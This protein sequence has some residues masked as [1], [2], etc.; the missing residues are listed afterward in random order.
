M[1]L[2]LSKGANYIFLPHAEYSDLMTAH[3]PNLLFI[4]QSLLAGQLPVWSNQ[5]LGGFPFLANPLSG[6]WYPPGW[7]ALL[8]PEPWGFNLLMGAHLVFGALGMRAY[9][10]AQG[11]SQGAA[12]FGALV[13][14]SLPKLMAHLAAGHLTL[15]YA[16]SWTP[17]LLLSGRFQSN[18]QAASPNSFRW[19]AGLILGLIFLADVRWSLFAGLVWAARG[20]WETFNHPELASDLQNL[21]RRQLSFFG[22]Q[23]LVLAIVILPFAWPFLELV[24]HSTRANITAQESLTFSLTGIDLIGLAGLLSTNHERVLHF[25]AA[26]MVLVVLGIFGQ[27]RRRSVFWYGLGLLSLILA[28]GNNI[29]GGQLLYQ[30]P[31]FNLTR[32]PSRWMFVSGLSFSVVAAYVLDSLSSGRGAP[33]LPTTRRVLVAYLAV[34]LTAYFTLAGLSSGVSF[35]W[36][37]ISMF[38]AAAGL[39]AVLRPKIK[40]EAV[41]AVAIGIALLD[42]AAISRALFRA[43]QPAEVNAGYRELI[44]SLDNGGQPFRTYSPDYSLPQDVAARAGLQLANGVDPIQL[45]TYQSF[46]QQAA[47]FPDQ[48]CS[49][50]LPPQLDEP[51]RTADSDLMGQLNVKFVLSGS[52]LDWPGWI[53]LAVYPVERLVRTPAD[54]PP[55]WEAQAMDIF[56]YE[57]PDVRPRLSLEGQG[58]VTVVQSRPGQISARVVGAGGLLVF[59]DI[60]YPGWQVTVNG[61]LTSINQERAPFLAVELPEGQHQV[62]FIFIPWSVYQ[63]LAASS[64]LL[65]GW[66]V[67]RGISRRRG[68]HVD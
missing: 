59:S 4:R 52:Q 16:I 24:N 18:N 5:F 20:L 47:Q 44:A 43:V 2:I 36:P 37:F 63:G 49:V 19:P 41:F 65:L 33:A 17:W 7:L 60:D 40:R 27:V 45:T 29:P 66:A 9:L 56:V 38:I 21:I 64:A 48:G 3:L 39:L 35:R 53:P 42:A 8:F 13:F 54:D 23:S 46:V 32:V 1:A 15:V 34:P 61:I 68:V 12:L 26:V 62:E 28:L 31:P 50:I 10:R 22:R 11:L 55:R 67:L 14:S 58:Q 6:F 57:N 25:G 51:W 30:L